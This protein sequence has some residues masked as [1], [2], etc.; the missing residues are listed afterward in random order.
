MAMECQGK[1]R[2]AACRYSVK[3]YIMNLVNDESFG[4]VPI[5]IKNDGQYLFCV[6]SHSVGYWAFPKGH[7]EAGKSD[8]EAAQKELFEETGIKDIDIVLN[9]TFVET[10][11]FD[12]GAIRYQKIAKYY[13]GFFTEVEILTQKGSAG[14]INDIKL[15]TYPEALKVITFPESRKLLSEVNEYLLSGLQ[16]Q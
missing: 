4:V 6:V 7:K 14:E 13:V 1:F 16:S 3:I 5:I 12:R 8:L 9:R 10:Y 15:L 11:P 2:C